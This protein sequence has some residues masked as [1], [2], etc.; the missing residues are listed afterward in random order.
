VQ[1][2]RPELISQQDI[3]VAQGKDLEANAAASA[4]QQE[5]LAAKAALDKDKTLYGYARMTAPFDGVVTQMHAYTGALLPAGTSSNIGNSALCHLA[6][7]DV[8][9]LVIPVPE[10]A[11]PS[12]HLGESVTVEVS[13]LN[14]SFKGEVARISDQIDLGTRTMHTE[15]DVPNRKYDLVPGMYATV[16]LPLQAVQ[17]ALTVPAQAVQRLGEGRGSVLVV[18]PDNRIEK[19]D[20]ALGL[21]DSRETEVTSGLQEGERVVFGEQ[22]QFKPGE[23]VSPT[24]VMPSASGGN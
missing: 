7:N 17:N 12:V 3:D 18:G 19:R 24:A 5:L 15:V 11:V 22:A 16:E 21:D 1:K 14:R 4:A 20:V 8:L 9:R 23:L 2:T 13:G 10:R 6:Q